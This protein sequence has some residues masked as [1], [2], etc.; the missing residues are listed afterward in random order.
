MRT[1]RF[2]TLSL[3]MATLL[4]CLALRAGAEVREL[5]PGAQLSQQ[6][7]QWATQPQ[8]LQAIRERGGPRPTSTLSAQLAAVDSEVERVR[9]LGER[10]KARADALSARAQAVRAIVES[11]ATAKGDQPELH[12]VSIRGVPP[13]RPGANAELPRAQRRRQWT[14]QGTT[15]F[16]VDVQPTGRPIVLAA[17]THA[18]ATWDFRIADGANVKKVI[19]SAVEAQTVTGL[20]EGVPVET[21]TRDGEQPNRNM[22][23]TDGPGSEQHVAAAA[24]LRE[25]T[26]L[27]IATFTGAFPY[28]GEPVVVGPGSADWVAQYA[29]KELEP[30][31]RISI[32]HDVALRREAVRGL[33]FSAVQF[34][35]RADVPRAAAP[36]VQVPAGGGVVVR[37]VPPG[38]RPA[39]AWADFSPL[40][41]IE[42]T[43]RTL[44]ERASLATVDPTDSTIYAIESHGVVRIDPGTGKATNLELNDKD[45]PRISWPS[46]LTFDTK[47]RRLLL[48]THG[49]S[50]FLYAYEPATG[51]W[52]GL[53]DLENIDICSIAYSPKDDCIYAVLMAGGG[54]HFTTLL[55]YSA[56]GDAT[57]LI[58]TSR[59]LVSDYYL[60]PSAVP[61]LIP[62]GDLLAFLPTESR[63]DAVRPGPANGDPPP[64]RPKCFLIDP[65]TGEVTYAGPIQPHA[66]GEAK[67]TDAEMAEAWRGLAA[68]EQAD[69]DRAA[70]RLTAGG[71]GTVA[72]LSSQLKSPAAA[73]EPQRVQGWI[74]ELDHA[75]FRRRDAATRELRTLGRRVEP[76]LREALAKGASAEAAVRIDGLLHD[77]QPAAEGAH[78]RS[79]EAQAIR[80]L[81]N[82][83]SPDAIALLCELALGATDVRVAHEAR[84]AVLDFT[85]DE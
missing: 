73:P 69:V 42:G 7:Y 26:G 46:G 21:Y 12:V 83:G 28:T 16:V 72:F 6:I 36:P 40:G 25:L 35:S 45:L 70:R 38:A 11:K 8:A 31:Y 44:P 1:M 39:P 30:L 2:R 56:E 80:V 3:G 27:E 71:T 17:C 63:M 20:P 48:S 50:G 57:R 52:S 82:I 24:K 15:S 41:P 29:L 18:R 74:A 79:R 37:I 62:V 84:A 47:R 61:Q 75:D 64:R 60:G 32:A 34:P 81:A 76:A 22:F 58:R 77:L 54:P 85:R 10:G 9:A 49:G 33:R 65:R 66:G 51:K 4:I 5:D 14:A 67:L 23:F 78:D 53:V 55:R 59:P 43:G 68:E 19:V 13:A